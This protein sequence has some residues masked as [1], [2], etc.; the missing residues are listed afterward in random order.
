MSRIYTVPDFGYVYYTDQN[1]RFVCPFEHWWVMRRIF[2]NK[3]L[4][5]YPFFEYKGWMS[6]NDVFDD[7]ELNY[8][9]D[10]FFIAHMLRHGFV[11]QVTLPLQGEFIKMTDRGVVVCN[12]IY[13]YIY[14]HVR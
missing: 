9:K 3:D 13:N 14:L 6:V 8:E 7:Y 5:K 12:Q 2:F 11:L 10:N 4:V 1:E